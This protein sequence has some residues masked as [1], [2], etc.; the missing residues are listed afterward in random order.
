[1]TNCNIHKSEP[2]DLKDISENL[3]IFIENVQSVP[4]EKIEMV[5]YR[6]FEKNSEIIENPWAFENILCEEK[7]VKH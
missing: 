6:Q 1:M 2:L 5:V 7:M 3:H 4:G